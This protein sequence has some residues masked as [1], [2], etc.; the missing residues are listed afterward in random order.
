[1]PEQISNRM[2]RVNEL[3][4]REIGEVIEKNVTRTPGCLTT[5]T[6]VSTSPD[7]RSARVYVSFLGGTQEL[8][9]NAF[10]TLL[11]YKNEIQ[12]LIN[13]HTHLK[14]TPVLSF[15]VDNVVKKGD[16]IM[17]IINEIQHK[18]PSIDE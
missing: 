13:K 5:V 6:E 1:M 17:R 9:E 10:K 16:K 7:L 4:K 14:Y 8:H 15:R 3:L 12:R 18:I 11:K 2:I